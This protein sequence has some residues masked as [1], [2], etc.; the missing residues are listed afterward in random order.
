[1]TMFDWVHMFWSA[2]E[3]ALC[4]FLNSQA[5]PLTASIS[6]KISLPPTLCYMKKVRQGVGQGQSSRLSLPSVNTN[7]FLS[8]YAGWEFDFLGGW[9]P[10]SIDLWADGSIT[11][12]PSQSLAPQPLHCTENPI[13]VLRSLNPNSYF[14][15]SVSDFY[16]PRIRSTYLAAAR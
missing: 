11:E 12:A 13:F 2:A 10:R 1:M 8:L 9:G 5:R 3:F 16:I 14:H 4:I 6:N 7:F 15:M